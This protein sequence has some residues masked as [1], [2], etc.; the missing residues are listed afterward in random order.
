MVVQIP[1]YYFWMIFIVPFVGCLVTTLMGKFGRARDYTAVLFSLISAIFSFLVLWPMFEGQSI[2]VVTSLIPT[3]VSWISGLGLDMGVLTDPYTIIL[4]NIVSWIGFLI[5]VYSLDY[6]RG[7]NGLTRYWFFMNFFLGSMQ[8]IVLSNNL[9][10][11]FIGWEGVGLASYAL[12]GFYYRDRTE[13]WVGT[14]GHRTLGEEQAYSPSHAGMKAFVMTR[15]GDMAFLAGF[16]ILFYYARTFSFTSLAA[17]ANNWVGSL[18]NAG[19][20]VPVA[21]LIFGGAV[22]KSAQFPL[23][24]WLPDAMAGPAPVSALIH[25][26]TM[27]NAGVILVARIGP[28]FYFTL[29]S[30]PSLI[31]PF[32]LTVAWIGAFTAFLAATQGMVGYE[33]K[34]I[35]AYS[36]ASQIGYMIMA[37]GLTGL[38]ASANFA[39]GLSSGLFHLMSQAI[40]KAALF[41][42]A[43]VLIHTTGS[44]YINEMGGL[45]DKMKITFAAVLIAAAALSGIPPLSGFWSKD[46]ILGTAWTSGQYE[47]FA[48]GAITAGITAFYTFRM[49]GIIFY[50]K[51]NEHLQEMES[52]DARPIEVSQVA[53]AQGE[54]GHVVAQSET[55]KVKDQHKEERAGHEPHESGPLAWVPY[56]LLAAMCVVI[57]VATPIFNLEGVIEKASTTYLLSLFPATVVSSTPPSVPLN[58]IPIGISLAFVAIGVGAAWALYIGRRTTPEN[59]VKETGFMH[60]LYQFLENRWYINAIYY[61]VFVDPTIEAAQWTLNNIE[62]KVLSKINIGGVMG[63]IDLSKG[64][65]ILDG[66]VNSIAGAFSVVGQALSRAARKMQSGILEQYT[67]IFTI[68]IIIILVL[69]LVFSGVKLP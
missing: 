34:K 9:L 26:A 61:R 56:T 7:D 63:G 50:G 14:P 10:S 29:I 51:K 55:E 2:S 53:L 25:A 58:L 31:Q 23:M 5:L 40:F 64:G 57:G 4:T 15:I 1:S 65:N 46:S 18:H 30:N 43:G 17:N 27:V 62:D 39:E 69:F 45:K 33:L 22:G 60:G 52:T 11:L 12:I 68:G 36:T 37:L 8:L 41:M 59:F 6:M 3:N 49:F 44:K 16:F 21:V 38:G 48:V 32:F 35:L 47:L 42:A 24:E 19:L 67:L 13:Y 54:T 28:I 66:V 20:L